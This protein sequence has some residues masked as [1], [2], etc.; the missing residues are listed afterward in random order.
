MVSPQPAAPARR[1]ERWAKG[2]QVVGLPVDP[3]VMRP[4]QPIYT[5]GPASRGR[6]RVGT[7]SLVHLRAFLLP[8]CAERVALDVHRHD[9]QRVRSRPKMRQVEERLRRR[10]AETARSDAG[11]PD[12]LLRAAEQALGVAARAGDSE[13]EMDASGATCSR[14]AQ[15]TAR[16]RQYGRTGCPHR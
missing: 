15:I 9:R 6:W 7:L 8:G 4:G 11:R 12:Q 3:A 13:E 1:L 14:D 10:L 16:R 5:A 2:A